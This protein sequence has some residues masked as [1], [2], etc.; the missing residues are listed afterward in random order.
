MMIEHYKRE[1]KELDKAYVVEYSLENLKE[2][3]ELCIKL[4]RFF[5]ITPSGE[6]T[7]YNGFTELRQ[8]K[9]IPLNSFVV[10]Y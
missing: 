10:L 7:F 2:F 8:C 6:A 9:P 5:V 1:R 4:Q 3:V